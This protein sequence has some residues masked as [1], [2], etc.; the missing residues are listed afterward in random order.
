MINMATRF[1]LSTV[2]CQE[3][4]EAKYAQ[5]TLLERVDEAARDGTITPEEWRGILAAER[6][7]IREMHEAVVAS[8]QHDLVMARFEYALRAGPDAPPHQYL[9]QKARDVAALTGGQDDPNRP[10]PP[11]RFTLRAKRKAPVVAEAQGVSRHSK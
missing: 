1:R 9:A 6:D 2:V 10:P 3:L 7:M 5:D 11:L 8:E 4:A